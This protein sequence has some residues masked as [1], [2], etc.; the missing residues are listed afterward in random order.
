MTS[1]QIIALDLLPE[2]ANYSVKTPTLQRD[3]GRKKLGSIG[4]LVEGMVAKGK[5]I[6]ARRN[7]KYSW[8][9]FLHLVE[10][11][12]SGRQSRCLS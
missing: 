12:S 10:E 4:F 8:H 5:V 11:P 7:L 6:K 2:A 1:A 9:A 3:T